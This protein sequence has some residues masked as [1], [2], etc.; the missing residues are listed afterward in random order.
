MHKYHWDGC[1]RLEEL[2]KYTQYKGKLHRQKAKAK[3]KSKYQK[4][5]QMT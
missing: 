2:V 4:Q 3:K 1:F 5:G